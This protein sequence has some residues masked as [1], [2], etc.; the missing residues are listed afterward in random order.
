MPRKGKGRG[1]GA[2]GAP[3]Q[4]F[5]PGADAFPELGA[6]PAAAPAPAAAA[7]PSWGAGAAA[8][9]AG[10]SVSAGSSASGSG[11]GSAAAAAATGGVWGGGAGRGPAHAVAVPPGSAGS[12]GGSRA[13]ELAAVSGPPPP[14]YTVGG[15]KKGA[16]PVSVEKRAK[17]KVVTVVC[18]LSGD[19]KALCKELKHALGTGGLIRDGTVS[20]VA[21]VR[22]C[23]CALG[24]SD[25][26]KLWVCVAAGLPRRRVDHGLLLLLLTNTQVE[27]QGDHVDR[28]VRFL[29]DPRRSACLKGVRH[30]VIE[31]AA[32]AKKEK[33]KK[34]VAAAAP[35]KKKKG[36]PGM[37]GGRK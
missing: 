9:M 26:S 20:E 23:V 13:S 1:R 33:K 15:T 18:N 12:A 10:P 31:A 19:L 5:T 34:P 17:G 8:P 28:V 35:K 16:M 7:A 2:A 21:H 11:Q 32:P 27:I 29:A 37:H 6:T 14:P 25:A 4:G 36:K 30:R 3:T 24:G 22:V